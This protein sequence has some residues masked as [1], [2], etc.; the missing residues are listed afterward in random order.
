MNGLQVTME[1]NLMRSVLWLSVLF[2][3]EKILHKVYFH[4]LL[5]RILEA[6]VLVV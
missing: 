3:H 1:N 2:H 4:G 5:T 6:C